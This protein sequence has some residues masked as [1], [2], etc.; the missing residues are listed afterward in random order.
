MNFNSFLNP[1][2]VAVVGV[3]ANSDKLGS[4][5]FQNIIE[6]HFKGELMAVNPRH[7]DKSL[8]GK[9]V[10]DRVSDIELPLDLVVIVVPSKFVES[11]V[12]DCVAN[13]TKNIIIISAGFGEIGDHTLE[14]RIKIKCQKND[15]NL[16]GPNCLGAILPYSH[17]NA[18]FSDGTPKKGH[19]CFV[20]QSGAF[21]TAV[22]DW[23]NAKDIGFS[24]FFSLGNKSGI[25][26]IEILENLKNDSKVEMFVFYLES[27]KDGARFMELIKEVIPNKPIIILQPGKS[28]KAAIAS[29]SHTG[30]L[31][32]DFMVAEEAYHAAGAI[33]VF[34]M[35]DMFS[36]IEMLTFS[37]HKS[38]GNRLG[39]LTNAGGVGVLTSDLSEENNLDLI[40]LDTETVKK[41]K[42]IL[43]PEAGLKN[44]VDIIG[45]AN[46]ERYENGLRVLTQN[47]EMDQILVLLTP[48]RSTE[49]EAIAK[50]IVD[51]QKKSNKNIV[52]S[53]IG[54]D[55]V[56][57]GM[58]ILEKYKV[59]FFKYP[60]E[61]TK[62][63]GLLAK[64]QQQK[65]KVALLND[66][67]EMHRDA[68]VLHILKE[69]KGKTSLTT[70]SV[71]EILDIYKI[72]RVKSQNFTDKSLALAFVKTIFPQAVVLKLS[73]PDALHKSDLQG[74]FLNIN[75]LDQFNMVWDKLIETIS[76][77]NILNATIEIQEQVES[78]T[79]V[80]IGM[81][82]DPNF[83]K[84]LVCGTGGIYTEIYKDTALTVLPNNNLLS[85]LEKTKIIE[86]LKGARG[87]SPKAYM[88]LVRT[89]EKVQQL[90]LDFP[91]IQSIDVN[92][93]LVTNTRAICVDF[94]I[95]PY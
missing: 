36:V 2:S 77:N 19:I 72:D 8:Y 94:K 34:S 11:V 57:A 18:S 43:P 53:F 82:T 45:D 15:I 90:V 16:L 79:E 29:L 26:E 89:M 56:S 78:G 85:V 28:K 31:A 3:S 73:A 66:S 75:S 76:S 1:K 50:V 9:P 87:N 92:P 69:N 70:E 58:D 32:P 55:K 80:L 52:A 41:L 38:F 44:P 24:H 47:S 22:L 6:S 84:V 37:K 39:V 88:Q 63:M 54:G 60:V 91:E 49:I 86:I 62:T 74:V 4:I 13:K 40:D 67:F 12:Y 25:S 20:S 93:I 27:L 64:Y 81:N 95:L 17:L 23:A 14:D 48:Q 35:R 51:W 10:F 46:S 61:A 42:M 33:Q 65:D 5:V 68:R 7:V 21:C 83:G 59:P 30:S 71:N